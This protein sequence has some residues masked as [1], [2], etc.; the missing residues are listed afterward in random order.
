MT[1]LQMLSVRGMCGVCG[2]D[3]FMQ[4]VVI[5]V[6]A[7]AG[8][9]ARR[10]RPVA[11][12]WL[13]RR[14]SRGRKQGGQQVEAVLGFAARHPAFLP[15]QEHCPVLLCHGRHAV[16][17]LCRNA[18]SRTTALPAVKARLRRSAAAQVAG[19]SRWVCAAPAAPAGLLLWLAVQLLQL[20]HSPPGL[21]R[22]GRHHRGHYSGSG[23][24]E[25]PSQPRIATLGAEH[26]ELHALLC[27]VAHNQHNM[28]GNVANHNRGWQSVL[29]ALSCAVGLCR[30]EARHGA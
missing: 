11:G 18:C 15:Q 27:Y 10:P 25:T 16:P 30:R 24:G 23:H 20:L 19:T 17:L 22:S 5:L 13:G 7:S 12:R 21:H 6:K 9:R 28:A 1:S 2:G 29:A 3:P 14:R 26:A 4:I 8:A